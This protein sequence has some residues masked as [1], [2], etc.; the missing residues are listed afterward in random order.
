MNAATSFCHQISLVPCDMFA[1]II[2]IIGKTL[3]FFG[4]N[5]HLKFAKQDI[6]KACLILIVSIASLG[7]AG[8]IVF[9][10]GIIGIVMEIT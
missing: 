9:Y 5:D 10:V 3:V 6:F 4:S 8:D 7:V 1:I 2:L